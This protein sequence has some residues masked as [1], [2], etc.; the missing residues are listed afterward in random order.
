MDEETITLTTS[1]I[2]LSRRDDNLL[3]S[4]SQSATSLRP[5]HPDCRFTCHNFTA[6]QLTDG[7]GLVRDGSEIVIVSFELTPEDATKTRRQPLKP[8]LYP[9]TKLTTLP[10]LLTL[11]AR[12]Y[13]EEG[14]AAI[15]DATIT[16]SDAEN[17]QI[18]SATVTISFTKQSRR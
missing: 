18:Q 15:I 8:F 4:I 1:E 6:Q 2:F 10:Q 11:A 17:D 14:P 5:V 13:T 16:I 7:D 3:T 12:Q 9:S